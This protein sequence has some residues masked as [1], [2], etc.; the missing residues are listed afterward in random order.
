MTAI[1]LEK[2]M[3]KVRKQSGQTWKSFLKNHAHELW[4]CDFTVV[5]TLFFKPCGGELS[6]PRH[7]PG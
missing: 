4:S 7:F 6:H 5:H 3:K 2:Y 1:V